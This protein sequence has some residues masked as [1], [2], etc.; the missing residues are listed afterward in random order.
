MTKGQAEKAERLALNV[1]DKWN[2]C[3]GAVPD[4]TSTYYEIKDIRR[5][6]GIEVVLV[7]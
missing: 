4:C 5:Y 1:F 2:E 6:S 7:N 3:T